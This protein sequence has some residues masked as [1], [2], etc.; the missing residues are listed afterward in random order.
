M[1]HAGIFRSSK[2]LVHLVGDVHQP[3][4][5][6]DRDGNK[7]GNGRLVFLL[8]RQRAVNLHS[9]WDTLILLNRKKA[10]PI[11]QYADALNACITAEQAKA[12]AQGSPLDW[13]NESHG[14]A[15]EKV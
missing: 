3:L 1:V 11:A 5:C 6:A 7:G 12:W 8:D 14:V 2:F 4:H 15:V 13:A 10:T 9:C